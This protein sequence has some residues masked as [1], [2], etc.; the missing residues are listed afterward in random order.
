MSQ[1]LQK[2]KRP[3]RKNTEIKGHGRINKGMAFA[4]RTYLSTVKATTGILSQKMPM[5]EIG[6]TGCV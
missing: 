4:N 6:M 5:A 3:E 1:E 2:H